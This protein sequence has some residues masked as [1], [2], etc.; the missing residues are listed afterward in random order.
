M[1]RLEEAVAQIAAKVDMPEL[2]SLQTA[3]EIQDGSL[4]SPVEAIND[5][6]TAGET[7]TSSQASQPKE[8]QNHEQPQTWEV[9]MDPRGGPSRLLVFQKVG[10]QVRQAVHQLPVVPT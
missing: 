3:P 1:R 10:R 5:G 8:N 7:S 6:V 2:H 9:V 4:G